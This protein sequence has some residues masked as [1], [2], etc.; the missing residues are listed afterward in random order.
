[1]EKKTSENLP[2]LLSS[3]EGLTKF[4]AFLDLGRQK[5]RVNMYIH[6]VMVRLVQNTRWKTLK[7]VNSFQ[8][9]TTP[10][11]TLLWGLKQET[12]FDSFHSP[13][14]NL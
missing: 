1:M 8:G 10:K 7:I 9:Q 11:M 14:F 13:P 3:L 12:V 2:F 5:I 4:E 6:P